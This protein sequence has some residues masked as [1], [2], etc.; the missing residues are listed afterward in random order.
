MIA[1]RELPQNYS[2]W[3]KTFGAPFGFRNSN[4]LRIR[5]IRKFDFVDI[6]YKWDPFSLQSNSSNRAFE[7]PWVFHN[8][9]G[10]PSNILEIGGGVSG[11]QF[12]LSRYGHRVVNVDPGQPDIRDHWSYTKSGFDKLNRRFGTSVDLKPTHIEKAELSADEFDAAY[13]ISVIEHLDRETTKNVMR[14]VWRCL[15]P[16]GLFLLTIDLFLNLT[17]FTRRE[18]NHYGCNA[19]VRELIEF[20]PFEL[21]F[22]LPNELYGFTEFS[23]E[24]IQSHL[25]QYLIAESYPVLTQCIILR[26][27]DSKP[28]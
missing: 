1:H 28:L 26:K 6:T 14:E 10:K 23:S 7:Y 15:K 12:V 27:A 5:L 11:L 22:G 13:S 21:K 2:D 18:T 17:P 9:P 24:E 20:A 16:G 8:L 19:D 3:N 25:E 4:R